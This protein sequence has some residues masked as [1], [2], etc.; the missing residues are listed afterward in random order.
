VL[1][2]SNP[3]YLVLLGLCGLLVYAAW[4]RRERRALDVLLV[5]SIVVA[6]LTLP[7]NLLT[8]SSGRNVIA[9]LPEVVLP[10]WL[11]SVAFGGEVTAESLVFALVRVAGLVAIVSMVCAF[12]AGVDHFRL[13]R[14][15]PPRIAQLGVVLTMAVVLVPETVSRAAT[16]RE[17]R[18]VRGYGG[19]ARTYFAM[20][21]PLF[22]ES[23]E[24]S[25]QRAESLDAR[26]FGRLAARP[27]PRASIVMVTCVAAAAALF[28][29]YYYAEQR[30]AIVGLA[31]GFAFAAC[32]VAVTRGQRTAVRMQKQPLLHDDLIV[33]VASGA[34]LALFAVM[35][36]AG[37]GA[38]TYIPFPEVTV[39]DFAL[40]AAAAIALLAAPAFLVGKARP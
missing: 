15:T 3:L 37:T 9:M 4:R 32:V 31:M 6:L 34:A 38:L 24:R 33:L 39:P 14:M 18:M 19:G 7:L 8:G 21:L 1:L 16:L 36:A 26:G 13:L 30:L 20:L 10:G 40:V 22:T 23:L 11:G 27:D 28:G 12:N 35:R 2:T 17:A 25:V 5:G 29:S